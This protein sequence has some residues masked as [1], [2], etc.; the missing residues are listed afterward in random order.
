LAL[1][2]GS[3][4]KRGWAAWNGLPGCRARSVG[5]WLECRAHGGDM[6]GNLLLA[7]IL[8]QHEQAGSNGN[9]SE[10]RVSRE[11]WPVDRLNYAYRS[12]AL[13]REHGP[14]LEY[15]ANMPNSR[16]IGQRPVAV[17]LAALLRLKRSNQEFIQAK[18]D[19]YLVQRRSTQPPG[20]SMGSMFKNPA[21]DAAGRL[22]EAAGLKGMRIGGAEISLMHA[23]FFINLGGAT[24]S[25]I[26]RLISV[27][28][29]R[30]A[31]KFGVEME[32][33]IE[34]IGN[35]ELECRQMKANQKINIAVL[36]GGR[37][38]EHEISLLSARSILS[39]LTQKI[40]CDAD[41]HH[42]RWRLVNWGKLVGAHVERTGRAGYSG[43][44]PGGDPARSRAAWRARHPTTDQGKI[45]ETE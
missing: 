10:I 17:V 40:Q 8:H 42:A 31:E 36:F 1:W 25:D 35:W 5:Q 32:L 33:E 11:E 30:V 9:M 13:K 12:S 44:D 3:L 23:N 45:R 34:L 26:W 2:R 15:L 7:E 20:A 41:R 22:I 38:G 18:M 28:R 19:E 39:V 37:S 21:G 43:I 4:L 14:A 6:A 27:A 24:A 16:L 29:E